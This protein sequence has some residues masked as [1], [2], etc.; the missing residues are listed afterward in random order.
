MESLFK[1]LA[2][3]TRLKSTPTRYWIAWCLSKS[4]ET[5]T[6]ADIELMESEFL[7]LCCILRYKKT[8][9]EGVKKD[10]NEEL[11]K[12]VE[13]KNSINT[14]T[15]TQFAPHTWQITGLKRAM[16]LRTRINWWSLFKTVT[17]ILKHFHWETRAVWREQFEP[18]TLNNNQRDELAHLSQLDILHRLV[19]LCSVTWPHTWKRGWIYLVASCRMAFVLPNVLTTT[20]QIHIWLSEFRYKNFN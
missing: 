12:S 1:F 13:D 2:A 9:R 4:S 5:L 6:L 10:F 19:P 14:S 18:S 8:P 20:R 16:L 11:K 3:I 17:Q 15:S 7:N